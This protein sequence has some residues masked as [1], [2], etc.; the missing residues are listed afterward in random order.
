MILV[1]FLVLAYRGLHC[2]YDDVVYNIMWEAGIMNSIR[3]YV[4]TLVVTL[5]QAIY[6][7]S[8]WSPLSY[9]HNH[10]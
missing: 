6:F 1:I 5:Y 8:G 4:N 10:E 9:C 3:L 7:S 2:F